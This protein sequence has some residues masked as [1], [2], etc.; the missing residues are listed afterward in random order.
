MNGKYASTLVL[1]QLDCQQA[2]LDSLQQE[3]RKDLI[4][5]VIKEIPKSF[6]DI[7]KKLDDANDT[8]KSV[9]SLLIEFQRDASE[10]MK[11]LEEIINR[12]AGHATKPE[13]IEGMEI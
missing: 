11:N 9:K 3:L 2:S 6:H 1:S 8:V 5:F 4:P 7:I 13:D 10:K 12:G